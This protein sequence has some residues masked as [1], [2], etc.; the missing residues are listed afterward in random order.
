M[1]Y[2]FRAFTQVCFC[3]IL[4]GSFNG[5]QAQTS[6]FNSSG[7]LKSTKQYY[8]DKA[9]D[10]AKKN[11]IVAP[12]VTT[13]A[14][15]AKSNSAVPEANETDL[16]YYMRIYDESDERAK[17]NG[18]LPMGPQMRKLYMERAIANEWPAKWP[19]S[20][21]FDSGYA[22]VSH[23]NKS[24]VID[25]KGNVIIPVA[26]HYASVFNEGLAYVMS[27]KPEL[28]VGFVDKQNT[29]V[30]P[31]KYQDC[32]FGFKNGLAAVKLND[33]WGY[34]NK[35]DV[36]VIPFIYDA[37]EPFKNGLAIVKRKKNFGVIDL[38]GNVIIPIK[39]TSLTQSYEGI[40]MCE[41][42]GKWGAFNEKGILITEPLY[43]EKFYFSASKAKV[44]QKGRTFFIDMTGK[45][46]PE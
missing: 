5:L 15:K 34:I 29:W 6:Q 38:V 41:S 40:F 24:G 18:V 14:P 4:T 26:W 9:A 17:R 43:D 16:E 12:A 37:A 28:K 7:D 11:K 19:A 31:L 30:I 21:S 20:Y 1:K 10:E 8:E 44:M 13:T 45:E 35:A 22:T 32:K 2:F 3:L 36:S 33:N 25:T 23:H 39:Y 27:P 42:K 46:V